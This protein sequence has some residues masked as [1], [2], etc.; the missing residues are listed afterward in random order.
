MTNPAEAEVAEENVNLQRLLQKQ[1]LNQNNHNEEESGQELYEPKMRI[2]QIQRLWANRLV[3]LL[4]DLIRVNL[5]HVLIATT[6]L[7]L[8]LDHQHFFNP[9]LTKL[10]HLIATTLMATV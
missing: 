9:C 3:F 10:K 5:I 8:P 6:V 7:N 4:L 2:S 1:N